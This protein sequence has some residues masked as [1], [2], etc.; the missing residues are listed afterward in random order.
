MAT[1]TVRLI[2][3]AAFTSAMVCVGTAS[4]VAAEP[5]A[6]VCTNSDPHHHQSC[7]IGYLAMY[8][9]HGPTSDCKTLYDKEVRLH[10]ADEL[11]EGD[12]IAGCEAAHRERS[13]LGVAG[14]LNP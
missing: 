5:L 14:D 2:V 11:L 9:P 1:K 12:F 4:P 7:E 3:G 6:A 10:P 8:I 13:A